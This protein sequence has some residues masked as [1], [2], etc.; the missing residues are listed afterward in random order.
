MNA[1]N[2]KPITEKQLREDFE[3]VQRDVT[4]EIRKYEQQYPE[5]AKPSVRADDVVQQP[6][7]TY[8]THAVS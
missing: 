4:E 5:L 1:N 6:V 7:Y 3:K 8:Q 2:D